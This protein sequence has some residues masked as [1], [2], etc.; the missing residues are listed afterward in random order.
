MALFHHKTTLMQSVYFPL[1]PLS[2]R[3]ERGIIKLQ[4]CKPD[5]GTPLGIIANDAMEMSIYN[6]LAADEY[7]VI[8][9]AENLG[10]PPFTLLGAASAT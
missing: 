9:Q 3:E 7:V 6:V 10:Y 1:R 5:P 8:R 2:R 4:Y